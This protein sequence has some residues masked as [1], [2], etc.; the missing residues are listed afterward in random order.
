L[1]WVIANQWQ[2]ISQY[3]DNDLKYR[4]IRMHEQTNEE[5]LYRIERQFQ[6]SDSI[7]IIR[8]QVERYE[9]LVKEQAEKVERAKRNSEE[10]E[11]LQNEMKSLKKIK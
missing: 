1:F 4:Y 7:K 3:K 2:T 5:D 8:R 10:V 11:Q 6:Y 9:E